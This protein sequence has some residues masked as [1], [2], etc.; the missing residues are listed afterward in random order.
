MKNKI[1]PKRK[2]IVLLL[3]LIL[4]LAGL[5]IPV[6]NQHEMESIKHSNK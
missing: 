1:D 2:L 5:L 3:I 6:S 4:L